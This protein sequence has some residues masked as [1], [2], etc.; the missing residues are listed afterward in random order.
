MK[1]ANSKRLTRE[2][3]AEL[4]S[5]AAVPDSAIDTSDAPELLDLCD[6]RGFIVMDET[7]DCWVQQKRRGDYHLVFADWHEKDTR[8]L[9]RAIDSS[10]PS[11]S[12]LSKRPGE[13]VDPVK[14]RRMGWNA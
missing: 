9:I 8:A 7:F 6:R 10:F 4:K 1:K 13:I 14:A 5:L 3:L 2:Q 12:R 11:N